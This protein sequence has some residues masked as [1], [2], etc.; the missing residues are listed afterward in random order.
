[1][2]LLIV[3]VDIVWIKQLILVTIHFLWWLCPCVISLLFWISFGLSWHKFGCLVFI[4]KWIMSF[5]L[6]KNPVNLLWSIFLLV[7]SFSNEY[8]TRRVV[9]IIWLFKFLLVLI[10][11]VPFKGL[12]QGNKHRYLHL[13]IHLCLSSILFRLNLERRLTWSVF[14]HNFQIWNVLLASTLLRHSSKI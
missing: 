6:F 11:L 4:W 2:F 7:V 8:V 1:M 9:Q 13:L 10:Q 14:N 3:Y 12:V 5:K